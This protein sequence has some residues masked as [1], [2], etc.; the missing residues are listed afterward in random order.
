MPICLRSQSDFLVWLGTNNGQF[1]VR[2][3]YHLAKEISIMDRCMCSNPVNLDNLWNQIW[4][5]QGSRVVKMFV[6][7]ACN[8]ILP[9]KHN[10][11]KRG[12][13]S[14]SN[15]PFVL[16]RLKHWIILFGA[17][18]L[19]WTCGL[20]VQSFSIS[21]LLFHSLLSI[22]LN[23]LCKGWRLMIYGSL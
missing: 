11:F 5:I 15:A 7:K 22:C 17:V 16:L 2:S 23:F 14:D 19:L 9:T 1:Y 4:N 3:A 18:L 21:V 8:D 6:W 20:N 13:V 12:I 10:L